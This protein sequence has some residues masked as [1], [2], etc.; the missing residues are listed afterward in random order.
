MEAGFCIIRGLIERQVCDELIE[1]IHCCHL[2]RPGQSPNL[3]NLLQELPHVASLARSQ[4]L[5]NE[6]NS[7]VTGVAFPVRAILFD[8]TPAA[9][10]SLGWHQDL[11]IA[12]R[13]RLDT[14]GFNAWSIKEGVPHVHPPEQILEQMIAARIHLDDC[15]AENGA[16]MVIPGSHRAGKLDQMAIDRWRE[17]DEPVVCAAQRGDVL[18]MR[19]L[20]LHA[21]QPAQNPARRR[22]LHIEYATCDLPGG[23]QWYEGNNP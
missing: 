20:L 23:L 12:V 2:G 5:L 9:N 17:S 6:I 3:R 22:V 19:P 4:R 8:K 13:E 18:L 10:W 14:P 11:A 1:A 21:S 7:A 16:L 15:P